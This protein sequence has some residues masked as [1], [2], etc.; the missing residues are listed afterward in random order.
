MKEDSEIKVWMKTKFNESK[1]EKE[2]AQREHQE[3]QMQWGCPSAWPEEGARPT[4]HTRLTWG[5]MD[6]KGRRERKMKNGK[7][8][9]GLLQDGYYLPPFTEEARHDEIF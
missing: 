4:G 6:S 8:D 9:N 1:E 5:D 7:V 2:V 3:Q